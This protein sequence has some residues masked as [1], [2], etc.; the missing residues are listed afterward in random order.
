M[1]LHEYQAKE[2]LARYGVPVPKGNVATTPAEAFDAATAAGGKV[3]VKAQ[4]HAGGRGRAGGVKLV[5]TAE[6][7][8][9]AAAAL[10]GTRLITQQS[11][12]GG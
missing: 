9:D 1:K 3:V 12:P 8:R 5:D 11:G 2:L 10:P 4:I 7:A 6:A